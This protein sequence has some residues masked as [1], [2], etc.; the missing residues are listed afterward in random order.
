M[1]K[2]N[3]FELQR[4]VIGVLSSSEAQHG[5]LIETLVQSFGPVLQE[6]EP[7]PFSFTDY[8]DKEM[9]QRPLRY[10]VVFENLVQADSL[11]SIKLKTNAIEKTFAFEGNRK[12]NLD[13][14]I[15]CAGSLILA[16]TKNRSHRIP[17]QDG[18]Y[19]ETTLIYYD[20]C[21]NALPWTYADY[22]SEPFR[23]LFKQYRSEY[24]SQLKQLGNPKNNSIES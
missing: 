20:H 13:P 10:F 17:L 7:V 15:L 1:G 16:T 24:L 8:Y 5:C 6:S 2:V 3:Q 19:G 12:I 18:I 9:G 22:K 11:S 21:F 14:G 23:S 4:L